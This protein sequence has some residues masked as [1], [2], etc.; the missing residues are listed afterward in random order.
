MGAS[1]VSGARVEIF[2]TIDSTSLEAK[3]R[4][5]MGEAGPVWFLAHRQTA[6]YGRRGSTWRQSDGDLAAT[7]LFRPTVKAECLPQLSFVAALAVADA[8]SRFSP[9]AQLSIKWPNDV[10]SAG[11]KI[12]GVLLEFVAS[13]PLIALGVGVNIVSSPSGLDYPTARLIDLTA[14]SAPP[15]PRDFLA[16]FD[17]VFTAWRQRWE[18]DGFAPVRAE[19]LSRADKIGK[20]IRVQLPGEIVEGAFQDLDLDG[21][22]ILDCNG[23][24]RSIAAGAVLP[25]ERAR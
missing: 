16:T 5:A 10:L 3:R 6:G 13:P 11:A 23:V 7:L 4:A 15:R 9:K 24:R 12:A 22:L 2:D 18:S 19:W 21:A 1:L 20:R 25:P 17:E 8:I 14:P